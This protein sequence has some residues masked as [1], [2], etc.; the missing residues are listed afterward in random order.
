MK[1]LVDENLDV[2]LVKALSTFYR[3]HDWESVAYIEELGEEDVLLLRTAR[4]LGFE[5]IV[6]LDL[7]QVA[8]GGEERH[9]I[10]STGL[11][12]IGVEDNR[13]RRGL[14]GRARRL[15]TIIAGFD[16][17]CHL[18]E[19]GVQAVKLRQVSDKE[20]ARAVVIW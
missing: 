1:I 10:A 19:Q 14:P 7:G 12:W 5:A 11:K 20:G 16:V 18:F 4:K 13:P 9:V 6:T 3:V 2:Q 8:E 17:A 15:A